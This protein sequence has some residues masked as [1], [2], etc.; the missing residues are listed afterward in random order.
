MDIALKLSHSHI[1]NELIKNGF[2]VNF[3]SP[4]TGKTAFRVAVEENQ[5]ET[6]LV[7]VAKEK[8]DPMI[9]FKQGM[10]PLVFCI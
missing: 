4:Q 2:D 10:D 7:L 8:L 9:G 3:I 1:V 5:V 6:K